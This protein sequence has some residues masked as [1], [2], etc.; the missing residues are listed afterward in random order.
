VISVFIAYNVEH[1]IT[2]IGGY[3]ESAWY[4]I[5]TNF[6]STVQPVFPLIAIAA[7]VMVCMFMLGYILRMIAGGR[8]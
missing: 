6:V 2:N 7:I 1:V 4:D 8:D 5:Y 3:N